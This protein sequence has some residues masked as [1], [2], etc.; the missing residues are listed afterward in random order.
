MT[1]DILINISGLQMDVD[2]ND[3]IEMMTTGAYYLRNGKHYILYDELSEDN[4]IV[5]NVIKIGQRVWN[6]Q[7][8]E[9]SLLIWSLKREKKTS[10]TTIHHLEVF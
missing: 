7:E 8:K 3:P 1:K 5:K 10:L 9:D 2:P 6:L 4:E